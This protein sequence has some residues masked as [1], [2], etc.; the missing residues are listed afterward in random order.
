MR[1]L[2]RS[3]LGYFLTPG[4]LVAMAALDSSLVFFLPLGI[5]FALII[6]TARR[7]ELFW[8]YSLLA[9]AGSVAGAAVTFWIGHMIGSPGLA[10]LIKPP[11]LE[12]VRNRVS[13]SAAVGVAALA[14]IPPPFPFTGFVLAS[15]ALGVN[16]WTF[17]ATLAGARLARFLVEAGLA[18]LYGSRILVW[19]KSTTFEVVVG[20]LIAVTLVGTAVS[21]V[22]LYR[23]TRAERG[24]GERS[25]KER[26]EAN[27]VD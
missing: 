6:V 7:P 14:L 18:A 24:V 23:S 1:S 21:A 12:G 8:A 15:G 22:A 5:D 26:R 25:A 4:G 13:R 2:F 27:R 17:F 20:A 19:M 11:R 16:P 10:R 3:F 9:T